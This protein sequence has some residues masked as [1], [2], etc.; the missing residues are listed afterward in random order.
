MNANESHIYE[1]HLLLDEIGIIGQT[2]LLAAKVAVI[3]AGGLGCPVLQYLAAAGVGDITIIDGDRVEQSNLQRQIL[4][5]TA[6]VG[7]FKANRAAELLHEKHPHLRFTAHSEFLDPNN[8]PALLSDVHLVLDC[9]DNFAARYLIN[10]VCVQLDLPFVYGAIYKFE[11]QIAVFNTPNSP[12][13]RCVFPEFPLESNQPNCSDTGV[14]GVLPGIIGIMQATEAIK[15][16]VGMEGL[17]NHSMLSYNVLHHEMRKI[18]LPK[19]NDKACLAIKNEPLNWH[20]DFC[21]VPE[22]ITWESLLENKSYLQIIDVRD[23]EEMP[24]SPDFTSH[25]IPLSTLETEYLKLNPKLPTAVYCQSGKRSATAV[26]WLEK[27]QFENVVSV[28]SGMSAYKKRIN[29]IL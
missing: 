14:I 23:P 13:Y 29:E 28:R 11:G 10:D 7:Q 6:D 25:Q 19:R 26:Q 18:R 8:A 16:I 17:L 9:T 5:G 27:H 22:E 24:K 1:K 20:P 3:G 4:Y 12:S 2:K 21:A 15:W